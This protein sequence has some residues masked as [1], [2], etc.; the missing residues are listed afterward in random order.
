MGV[1]TN[2]SK[3]RDIPGAP[4]EHRRDIPGASLQHWGEGLEGPVYSRALDDM[5]QTLDNRVRI[6]ESR[7]YGSTREHH[8][9]PALHGAY[10]STIK[11]GPVKR[12][13][14]IHARKG[15]FIRPE[16]SRFNNRNFL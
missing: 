12:K 15:P 4:L 5:I 13:G 7:A 8:D 10:G 11:G 14:V 9:G 3:E 1:L 16:S 6:S 2:F